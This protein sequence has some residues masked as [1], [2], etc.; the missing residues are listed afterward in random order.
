MEIPPFIVAHVA[1]W[2]PVCLMF[3]VGSEGRFIYLHVD[4]EKFRKYATLDGKSRVIL[5]SLEK[6][7]KV[8]RSQKKAEDGM[9][10]CT[11]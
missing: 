6:H 3:D 7:K 8:I 9:I 11:H 5:Q 4:I 10:F 2:V 1:F